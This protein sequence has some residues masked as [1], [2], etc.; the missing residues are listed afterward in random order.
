MSTAINQNNVIDVD[1]ASLAAGQR[2]IMI[3]TAN[4]NVVI[5]VGVGSF[6]AGGKVF[7]EA[8]STIT[9]ENGTTV[10]ID[11]VKAHTRYELTNPV[12]TLTVSAIEDS[13]FESEI[14]FTAGASITVKLP[15]DAKFIGNALFLP[16]TE[17]II[18]IKNST[19]VVGV[20]A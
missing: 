12:Q 5:P 9:D 19:I 15:A 1:D 11:L 4:G 20:I 16:N 13:N 2:A 8:Q 7:V 10:T 17:Y 18:V 14:Q 6:V 3:E